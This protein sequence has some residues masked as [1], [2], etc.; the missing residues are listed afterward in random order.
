[1][2]SPGVVPKPSAAPRR[3]T[4]AAL[5]AVLLAGC[6]VGRGPLARVG[7][8]TISR[9]EFL[10][11]ARAEQTRYPGAPDSAKARLLDDLIRQHLLIEAAKEAGLYRDSLFLDASRRAGEYI[12]RERM[13]RELIGGP[14][15]VTPGEVAALYRARAQ[16]ARCRIVFAWTADLARIASAEL[17]GGADFAAVANHVNP[18]GVVP[19]GGDLGFVV[20]GTLP[21]SLDGPLRTAPLGQLIGPLEVPGQG[22]FLMRVEQ[23]RPRTQP[24]LEAETP[25]LAE[26]I[27]Q[28]KQREVLMRSVDRLRASAGI[29]VLPGAPERMVARLLPLAQA[30]E[31]HPEGPHLVETLSTAEQA[32]VLAEYRGGV[33]TLGDAAT[34]LE[35]PS[36]AR[37]NLYMTPVVARWIESQVLNRVL[38]DEARRRH[39]DREPEFNTT[40]S[41]LQDRVLVEGY[42]AREVNARV[43]V[44]EQELR[45]AYQRSA[46]MFTRLEEARLL[47]ATLEDSAVASHL[48][49][50]AFPGGTL[51]EVVAT[52]SLPVRVQSETVRFPSADPVWQTLEPRLLQMTAGEYAG[53]VRAARGWLVAQLQSKAQGPPSFEALSA[54]ERSYLQGQALDRL[55]GGRILALTDSLRRVIR[56]EVHRE[57]LR[58]IPWPVPP[59]P[60][61]RS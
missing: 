11:V 30:K 9:D 60:N 24:T 42:V 3:A 33:Y 61:T 8:H 29:R 16:E 10:R 55:R 12:L 40:L 25:Q 27:R 43:A 20:P 49:E 37:P 7:S 13:S 1:M 22:W 47:T 2:T 28:T 4:V 46:P 17:R 23:R 57:R 5:A 21:L 44:T 32:S 15:A 52:A 36:G 53:P 56:V 58:S 34:D 50:N 38:V 19:P 54:Q 31:Q 35:N 18:P 59:E 51:R 6:G 48:V 41:Q 14:I 26:L 39:Y 45:Q